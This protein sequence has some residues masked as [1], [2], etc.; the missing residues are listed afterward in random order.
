MGL[1]GG[2]TTTEPASASIDVAPLVKRSFPAITMKTS[3][4]S[5]WTCCGGCAPGR[6]RRFDEAQSMAGLRSSSMMRIPIGP[7]LTISPS[8][9]RTIR[10]PIATPPIRPLPMVELPPVCSFRRPSG[11]CSHRKIAATDARRAPPTRQSTCDGPLVPCQPSIDELSDPIPIRQ[12]ARGL[13]RRDPA[14]RIGLA[15]PGFEA[16]LDDSPPRRGARLADHAFSLFMLNRS[17]GAWVQ[18]VTLVR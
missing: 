11:P 9:G 17:F 6:N 10:I 5:L 12:L 7:A 8:P 15:H 13:L 14:R 1:A 4:C 2:T 18:G 16:A 3:S